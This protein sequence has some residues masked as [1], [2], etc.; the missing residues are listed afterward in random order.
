M[1]TVSVYAVMYTHGGGV[2]GML[3]CGAAGYLL[4]QS[5]WRNRNMNDNG[6]WF[7]AMP[8]AAICGFCFAEVT[9]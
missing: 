7:S 5:A 2:L 6:L 9:I 8:A 4:V 1:V 3:C